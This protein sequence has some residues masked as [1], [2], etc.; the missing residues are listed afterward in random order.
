MQAKG[1]MKDYIKANCFFYFIRSPS[2]LVQ[3]LLLAGPDLLSIS[4]RLQCEMVYIWL[5]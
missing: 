5:T 4:K 2:F 3:N 1:H